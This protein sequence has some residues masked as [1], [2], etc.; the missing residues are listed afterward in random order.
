MA[1]KKTHSI[2]KGKIKQEIE[3][4]IKSLWNEYSINTRSLSNVCRK[5]AFGEGAI[6]WIFK[7]KNSELPENIKYILFL[8]VLFLLFDALQYLTTAILYW[9]FAKYYEEKNSLNQLK[10]KDD[11]SKPAWINFPSKL[12][13]TIKIGYLGIAT[14]SLTTYII[15]STSIK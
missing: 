9:C 5:I 10:K 6:C 4:K 2:R 3:D 13:S 8:L 14:Y 11:V 7:Y 12:C 1:G 15:F